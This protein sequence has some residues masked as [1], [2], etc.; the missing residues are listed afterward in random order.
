[1]KV[2]LGSDHRGVDLKSKI[3]DFLKTKGHTV[4]DLGADSKESVDYPDFASLVAQSIINAK[5][6]LGIL[7]CGS[8]IGMCITANKYRG[9]RAAI[10]CKPELAVRARLH[11]DAN[12]LCLGA[13]F[14]TVPEA[15]EIVK[16]FI[17]TGFEG[18]R[19]QR[20]LDKISGIE[21]SF[22]DNK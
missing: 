6:E 10:C 8:G 5:A 14:I 11:N 4:I 15:L 13:D 20:R 7:I 18:G 22:L 21:C 19:H 1:M 3:S 9:I 12:V 2:A 16:P 17:E